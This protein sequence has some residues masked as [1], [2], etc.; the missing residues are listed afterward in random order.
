MLHLARPRLYPT[1]SHPI[2]VFPT[3]SKPLDRHLSCR[4]K[5]A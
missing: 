1:A 5:F 3:C 2:A 4:W